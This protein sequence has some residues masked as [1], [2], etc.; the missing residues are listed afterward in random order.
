MRELAERMAR[1][2]S[3]SK[4]YKATARDSEELSHWIHRAN[5]LANLAAFFYLL[6]LVERPDG[7]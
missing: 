6:S 7:P 4:R 3:Q 5:S 2:A 1:M